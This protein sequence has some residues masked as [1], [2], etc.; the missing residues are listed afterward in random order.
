[1]SAGNRSKPMQFDNRT[2]PLSAAA[3]AVVLVSPFPAA[4]APDA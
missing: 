1:M 3:V 2:I 4:A